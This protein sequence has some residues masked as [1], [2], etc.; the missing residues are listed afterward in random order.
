M[1]ANDFQLQCFRTWN[2]SQNERDAMFNAALGLTGEAGE[3]ADLLKKILCHGHDMNRTK[4]A[5]EI[6]DV[7]YYAA[8][9]A[10]YAGFE[11]SDV[12]QMNVDKLKARYPDG[13]SSEASKNRKE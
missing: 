13:F 7:C 3:V 5:K 11:L 1:L 10:H 6:G 4:L 9:L 8:I 12:L 2:R